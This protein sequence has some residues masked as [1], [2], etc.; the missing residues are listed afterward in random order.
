MCGTHERPRPAENDRLGQ[1]RQKRDRLVCQ[2]PPTLPEARRLRKS[3][4]AT[5]WCCG[6]SRPRPP[7][8][9][10]APSARSTP[11]PPPRP[12]RSGRRGAAA[13]GRRPER[14]PWTR[15][16]ANST[17]RAKNGSRVAICACSTATFPPSR[18]CRA[19]LKRANER[20]GGHH[21]VPRHHGIP[22][23]GRGRGDERPHHGDEGH[24]RQQDHHPVD[25]KGV[26]GKPAMVS[27]TVA[28]SL[29]W[30]ICPDRS[31]RDHAQHPPHRSQIGLDH[32]P[33]PAG[34]AVRA[35]GDGRAASPG[36]HL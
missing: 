28:A 16:D 3:A 30:E 36:G 33:R 5:G 7:R 12:R 20:H 34:M 6:R 23:P 35:A 14:R 24:Q 31:R 2:S 11:A 22:D 29:R 10:N 4:Q 26:D 9:R 1:P 19:P 21:G 32:C 25:D 8:S 18:R 15:I 17:D 13:A 27:N